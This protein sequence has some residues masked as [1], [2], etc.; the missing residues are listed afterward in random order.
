MKK[1]VINYSRRSILLMCDVLALVISAVLSIMIAEKVSD[2][3]FDRVLYVSVEDLQQRILFFSIVIVV[4]LSYFSHKG[5]YVWRTPWWQQ[6]AHVAAFFAIALLLD[7]FINFVLKIPLTRLWVSLSWITAI[8]MVLLTRWLGRGFLIR[9]NHWDIPT[10]LV[11]GPKGVL[12]TLFALKSE[13]Y[14]RYNVKAVVLMERNEK[15]EKTLKE[16]FPDVE[17][18]EEIPSLKAHMF[19][20]FA[21]DRMQHTQIAK[22]VKKAEKAKARYA[23][24]PPVCGFSLSGMQSQICFGYNSWRVPWRPGAGSCR[25]RLGD[26][27]RFTHVFHASQ[28]SAGYQCQ[29]CTGKTQCTCA[30]LQRGRREITP[31][32]AGMGRR[33]RSRHRP[34]DRNLKE[35]V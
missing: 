6:V 22:L 24:V 29:A 11:G 26:Q 17:V 18:L 13:T 2:V 5:H 33:C 31:I 27:F 9:M 34:K 16:M 19:V 32:R 21:P 20:V 25:V 28:R 4:A 23:I 10:L 30:I 12:E 1:K 35:R 7:G 3:F 14:L 8:P 15:H